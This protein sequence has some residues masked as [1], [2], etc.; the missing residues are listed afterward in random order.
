V[1]WP[2]DSVQYCL[3]LG[4]LSL[5]GSL[6]TVSGVLSAALA[7]SASDRWL[8]CPAACGGGADWAGTID[9]IETKI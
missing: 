3:I 1:C 7:A 2:D 6:Q 4:E 5:N 8:I 9:V